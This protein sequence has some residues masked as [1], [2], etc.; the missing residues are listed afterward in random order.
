LLMAYGLDPDRLPNVKCAWV[1][2]IIAN[3]LIRK[4]AIVSVAVNFLCKFLFL[5]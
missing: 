5:L 1:G 4:I 2:T 3:V